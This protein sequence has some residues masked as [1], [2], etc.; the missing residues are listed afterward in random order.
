MRL[1]L[2]FWLELAHIWN[3]IAQ[4]AD[5][6]TCETATNEEEQREKVSTCRLRMK[7]SKFNEIELKCGRPW[8]RARN[9]C[10]VYVARRTLWFCCGLR[11]RALQAFSFSRNSK[12]C[13]PFFLFSSFDR[14]YGI[15]I[16]CKAVPPIKSKDI[17]IAER[18]AE[19]RRKHENGIHS[20][21]LNKQRNLYFFF[22]EYLPCDVKWLRIVSI[23]ISRFLFFTCN[24][25]QLLRNVLLKFSPFFCVETNDTHIETVFIFRTDF[26]LIRLLAVARHTWAWYSVLTEEWI[27]FVLLLQRLESRN[28]ID[29]VIIVNGGAMTSPDARKWYPS[30]FHSESSNVWEVRR[31]VEPLV[32]WATWPSSRILVFCFVSVYFIFDYVRVKTS[33]PGQRIRCICFQIISLFMIR[34]IQTASATHMLQCALNTTHPWYRY[35]E[36]QPTEE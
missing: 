17:Y 16:L 7:I 18:G 34:M 26:T 1:H 2:W 13:A 8:N 10:N 22:F 31:H 36:T 15:S 27:V 30:F 33:Q 19:W 24:Q 32:N 23:A 3:G 35:S 21:E 9:R 20:Q 4:T 29:G 14:D 11:S 6:L 12:T 25:K 28:R 5:D